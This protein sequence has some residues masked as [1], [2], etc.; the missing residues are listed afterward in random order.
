M[1]FEYE[2]LTAQERVNQ[3]ENR[4]RSLES[5]HYQSRLNVLVATDEATV[6]SNQTRANELEGQI[7]KL[8]TERTESQKELKAA[9]REAAQA[10]S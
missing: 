2:L 6:T 4:L 8:R 9:N 5:D 7:G 1:A 3:I 10:K